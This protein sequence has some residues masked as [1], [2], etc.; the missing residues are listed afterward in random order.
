M[1]T[2]AT[3]VAT[4]MEEI[5]ARFAVTVD[6]EGNVS[7]SWP[8]IDDVQDAVAAR[9][10]ELV[11]PGQN[12]PPGLPA[13]QF[14]L[15]LTDAEWLAVSAAKFQ[16]ETPIAIKAQI[17]ALAQAVAMQAR[18]LPDEPLLAPALAM[19]VEMGI[20]SEQRAAEVLAFL[21]PGALS[22]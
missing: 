19:F 6:G 9:L 2:L 17:D 21:P 15:L 5:C 7:A 16:P 10:P 13:E 12:A 14:R 1:T 20:L 18:I 22:K 8:L 11:P 4:T 3:I